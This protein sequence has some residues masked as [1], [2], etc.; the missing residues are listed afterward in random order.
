MP[1][2]TQVGPFP[3]RF[4]GVALHVVRLL[5]ALRAHRLNVDGASTAGIPQGL[6][7]HK[8]GWRELVY[9]NPLHL[10][11][12]EGNARLTL[13]IGGLCKLR[14]RRYAL[15]VH[16]FRKR[17]DLDHLT[18]KLSSVYRGASLIVAIS[19]EV[20]ERVVERLGISSDS[21]RV[22]SSALPISAWEL[23]QP[24]PE[25]PTEWTQARVRVLANAGRVVRYN[26]K[27][28][29]GIDILIKAFRNIQIPDAALL[30]V[31]GTVVDASLYAEL[32]ALQQTDRRIHLLTNV[33]SPLTTI[34]HTAHVV[35]RPTRTEGG[36]SLTLSEAVEL[37]VWAVGS[38]AVARSAHTILF[39]TEDVQSLTNVLQDV[40]QR[41]SPA[42]VH[43]DSTTV[44][45]LIE[46]YVE[47]GLLSRV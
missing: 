44:S 23:R 4:G 1:D 46:A 39:A 3:G 40:M 45:A 7:V 27:D 47:H 22:F 37:G 35:V 13:L 24:A 32:T 2:L 31:L 30:I 33:S 26:G 21:V 17:A 16:S 8:L 28:L 12:D 6:G 20:K 29:Y 25:V 5:E 42:P 18:S 38:N 36:E 15:T 43:R 9:G 41:T 34:T 19:N 11:T 10:H 14:Q